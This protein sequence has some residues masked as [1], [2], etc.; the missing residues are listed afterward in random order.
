MLQS[1]DQWLMGNRIKLFNLPSTRDSF[2]GLKHTQI[3][4]E[5]IFHASRNGQKVGIAILTSDKMNFKRN[6]ITKD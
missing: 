1:E 4:S 2:Q 5:G 6:T 3:K